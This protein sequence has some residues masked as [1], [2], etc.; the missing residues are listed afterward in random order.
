[1]T[2]N[3]NIY[4][5][6]FLWFPCDFLLE[7][8]EMLS[9]RCLSKPDGP[10]IS[11]YKSVCSCGAAM[12]HPKLP[13]KYLFWELYSGTFFGLYRAL[14]KP[15]SRWA[16]KNQPE[17]LISACWARSQWI[18]HPAMVEFEGRCR[19]WIG[20]C[21]LLTREGVS[22]LSC[23]VCAVWLP[24]GIGSQKRLPVFSLFLC[25]PAELS[26]FHFGGYE[27]SL[28]P[29]PHRPNLLSN[30]SWAYRVQNISK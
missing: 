29:S 19:K 9:L 24:S 23:C 26:L 14:G 5:N 20:G 2:E 6:I 25:G 21:G 22:F 4:S 10:T 17:N 8:F 1:M 12:R 18:F 11:L 16:G 15:D 7:H 3:R 27:L 28:F 13:S 30:F